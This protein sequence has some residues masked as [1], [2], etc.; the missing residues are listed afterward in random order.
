MRT[1]EETFL[2]LF[3]ESLQRRDRIERSLINSFKVLAFI[4]SPQAE[5][6]NYCLHVVASSIKR[7]EKGQL[8]IY[9]QRCTEVYDWAGEYMRET[10]RCFVW[11]EE[12][13]YSH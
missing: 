4:Q 2:Q 5:S 9:L 1:E 8:G 6:E 7:E 10:G 3:F 12:E 13:E 11:V